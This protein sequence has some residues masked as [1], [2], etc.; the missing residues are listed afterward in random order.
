VSTPV[1][2]PHPAGLL[3]AGWLVPGSAH[4]LLGKPGKA[5]LFFVLLVGTF[6]GGMAICGFD[7]VYYAP[8][9]WTALAQ[10][11]AGSVAY[12]GTRLRDVGTR[13]DDEERPQSAPAEGAF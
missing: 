1:R 9:R 8:R 5:V 10:L 4:W 6:V 13:A 12:A 2:T 11:P 7:N 3:V